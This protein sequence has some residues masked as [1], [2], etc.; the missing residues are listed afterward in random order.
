MEIISKAGDDKS[1]IGALALVK[2]HNENETN[3]TQM[4]FIYTPAFFGNFRKEKTISVMGM[5]E[6]MVIVGLA[7]GALVVL[8]AIFLHLL[9]VIRGYS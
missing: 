9:K 4:S 3:A 1:Y 2:G 6:I 8:Y 5:F 7:L